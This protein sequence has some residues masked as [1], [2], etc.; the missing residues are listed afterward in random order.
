MHKEGDDWVL[1][2]WVEQGTYSYER[3]NHFMNKHE[4]HVWEPLINVE[5]LDGEGNGT[6][7]AKQCI[8][9][10]LLRGVDHNN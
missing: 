10:G 5:I 9:C 2:H 6:V 7:D 8:M 4:V 1:D 3:A